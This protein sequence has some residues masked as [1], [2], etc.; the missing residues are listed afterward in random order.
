MRNLFQSGAVFMII[1]VLFF[2]A[3]AILQVKESV[4][5]NDTASGAM[6]V[7]GLVWLAIGIKVRRKNTK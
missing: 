5:G 6:V 3:A 1:A 7:F 2:M 4:T